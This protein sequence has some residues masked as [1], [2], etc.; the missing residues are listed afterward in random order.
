MKV[1]RRIERLL[2]AM[3]S[4]ETLCRTITQGRDGAV[5]AYHFEPSGRHAPNASCET[6]IRLGLVTPNDDG[7]LPGMSQTW[8]AR[9]D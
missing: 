5:I 4:G 6:A 8:R 9:E 1:P 7:V 3:R 2:A